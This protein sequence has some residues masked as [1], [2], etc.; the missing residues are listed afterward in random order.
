[1]SKK[2]NPKSKAKAAALRSQASEGETESSAEQDKA[3]RLT[4][5]KAMKALI[6]Q[7]KKQGY[8]TYDDINSSLP[9]QMLS[10][11][12]ID[13]TLILFDD[14]GIDIID[15]NN[16]QVS[17]AKPKQVQSLSKGDDESLSDYGS[18]TD[19]VK[20]YLREMG[21]VTLL[22]R[23]GEVE[24]AKKIESE[25]N[26]IL[27]NSQGCIISCFLFIINLHFCFK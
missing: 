4:T 17:K 19:P 26:A 18:V 24:I 11:D 16:R 14:L 6:A 7:G 15:G 1:M 13:E 22:S 2:N 20:M 10:A 21:L 5:E 9:E 25:E 27:E 12:Q 23:E 8:L 3:A